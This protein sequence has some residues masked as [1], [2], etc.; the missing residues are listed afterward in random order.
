M[1][2]VT[3]QKGF[4]AA[5]EESRERFARAFES[6]GHGVV[7]TD[8]AGDCL[9][10]NPEMIRMTGRPRAECA[11]VNLG[12]AACE[13]DRA[14]LKNVLENLAGEGVESAR[15]ELRLRGEDGKP[16]P[17]LMSFGLIRDS[18][19]RPDSIVCQVTDLTALKTA[20]A[21]LAQAAKMEAVGNLTGG[22]A[23]DFNNLLGII[24]GN[25][26]LLK[27][28][29]P[30]D[31]RT[32]DLI[33]TAIGTTQRGA[34]LTSQLL[35]F[36]SRQTLDPRVTDVNELIGRM[37]QI[38]RRTLGTSIEIETRLGSDVSPIEIDQTLLETTLL[39][40]AINARDA[41]DGRGR[42]VFQTHGETLSERD[43]SVRAAGA[44]PGPH[45]CISVQDN[46]HGMSREVM[47]SI[48]EPFFTTKA[49]EKGTGLGLSMV[50]G[51]VRQSGGHI[52]V[53]SEEGVGTRFTLYFPVD[54]SASFPS[55]ICGPAETVYRGSE[56]IL[57]VE[58]EPDF[59]KVTTVLL[60]EL[61]YTVRAAQDGPAALALF[62][63]DPDID[64]L[65]TD[66]V[67]PGG[68]NGQEVAD[69]IRDKAPGISV[70]LISG[71]PQD[72]F[73]DGRNYPFLL[74]PYTETD[75]SQ[76]IRSALDDAP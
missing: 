57:L 70:L 53:Y 5:L 56:T 48:F 20:E 29:V 62:D 40:L 26:Q 33:D 12:E 16:I 35:A 30:S 28:R 42:L 9:D 43:A 69:R 67:M 47:A 31:E 11:G 37:D 1:L 7:I 68:L 34:L 27:R 4:E 72:A 44:R 36:S 51:F 15:L 24:L 13:E 41:M 58:D 60:Q 50:Y 64:L 71:F 8:L 66:M 55:P 21:Q 23:H 19:R 49:M 14:K 25:L 52:N 74:K 61:G 32:D 45:V 39:N 73:R 54:E 2:D 38:L 76:A 75:L 59:R 10:V 63:S 65:V 3:K 6:A 46:G 17:V 22:I 18:A